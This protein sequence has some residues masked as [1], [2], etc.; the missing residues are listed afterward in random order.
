MQPRKPDAAA[1][2]LVVGDVAADVA[3]DDDGA[4]VVAEGALDELL[5]HAAI[6]MLA[7][8][9]AAAVI[10]AVF[11]T[12]S[13]PGLGCAGAPGVTGLPSPRL[14]QINPAWV[15]WEDVARSCRHVVVELLPSDPG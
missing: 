8:V 9:T 2:L 3:G 1:V 10:N 11:F 7:A 4:E 15:F 14:P 6:S 12:V 5:P 13:S